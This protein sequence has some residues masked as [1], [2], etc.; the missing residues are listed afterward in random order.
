MGTMRGELYAF[1]LFS[2]LLL[3]YHTE[4]SVLALQLS[5]C[6]TEVSVFAS[7]L[8]VC[9]TEICVST[10]IVNQATPLFGSKLMYYRAQMR[11]LQRSAERAVARYTRKIKAR[12][13]KPLL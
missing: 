6:N 10:T 13:S 12:R 5:V 2:L 7:E 8:S 9:S 11:G 1:P 4:R 3:L